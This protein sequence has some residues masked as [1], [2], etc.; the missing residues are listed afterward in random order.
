MLPTLARRGWNIQRQTEWWALTAKQREDQL[1]I[2]RDN[3]PL[4]EILNDIVKSAS[5]TYA[6]LSEWAY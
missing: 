2:K 4:A 3:L 6:G 1:E 5:V